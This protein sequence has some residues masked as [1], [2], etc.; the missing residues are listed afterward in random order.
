MTKYKRSPWFAAD[1]QIADLAST[2]VIELVEMM[3]AKAGELKFPFEID[4]HWL[5]ITY[6]NRVT[7]NLHKYD[8]DQL[9][10]L[11]IIAT[12]TD[13]N[14]VL[15]VDKDQFDFIQ[16]NV[17]Y[18][19]EEPSNMFAK[20]NSELEKFVATKPFSGRTAVAWVLEDDQNFV[21]LTN[22]F[23]SGEEIGRR[24]QTRP[25]MHLYLQNKIAYTV[26][27]KKNSKG[28][29]LHHIVLAPS[30]H[31]TYVHNL[32]ETLDRFRQKYFKENVQ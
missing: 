4:K 28:E 6:P 26:E 18:V 11:A 25:L 27:S 14:F 9:V 21:N 10:E 30:S 3:R 5:R 29:E 22:T 2:K 15:T 20:L 12:I 8:M 16:P 32:M 13:C 24:F 1:K 7:D 23:D 19:A 31:D 17:D